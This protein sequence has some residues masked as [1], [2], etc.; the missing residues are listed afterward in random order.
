MYFNYFIYVKKYSIF[1]NDYKLFVYKTFSNDILHTLGEIQY[2][3]FEDIKRIQIARYTKQL[4]QFW[5]KE[6]F[7]IFVWQDKYNIGYKF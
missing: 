1:H 7:D 6:G 4:E 2:R 3:T 5:I